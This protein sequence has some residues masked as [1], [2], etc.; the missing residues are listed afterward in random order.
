MKKGKGVTSLEI[1]PDG[2]DRKGH[3]A[4]TAPVVSLEY[5]EG[6]LSL[7]VF[8]DRNSDTFTHKI[9]LAGARRGLFADP[10]E[11]FKQALADPAPSTPAPPGPGHLPIG[12]E[13]ED[14][15]PF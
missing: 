4:G 3:D 10:V 8:A 2:H 14:D 13:D 15:I 11:G 5:Y 7:R 6:E 1:F 12:E 9:S